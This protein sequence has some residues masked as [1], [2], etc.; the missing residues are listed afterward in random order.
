M[1][2]ERKKIMNKIVIVLKEDIIEYPPVISILNLLSD[3]PYEIYFLGTYTDVKGKKSLE[4]KG[5]KFVDMPPYDGKA[6]KVKKMMLQIEFRKQV[7]IGLSKIQLSKDDVL[8]LIQA[9]TIY[10]LSSLVKK[11]KTICHFL[12]FA[13]NKVDWKYRLLNPRLNLADTL[14]HAYR[15]VCCEYNR[16]QIAKGIFQLDRLPVVLPNKM[17]IN[18]D[19]N[20]PDDVA[21]IIGE[22][23]ERLDG[24]KI[25]LYQGIFLDKERRLEEFCEAMGDLPD[26]YVFIAMG[27]GSEMYERLRK[28]YASDRILFIPF[29]R[30]PY[31]LQVTKMA[32]IG[33]LSYFPRK[34]SIG[35][36]LNPIY[37]APN[38]I[39]EYARFGV[40]M[41]SN[42]IPGLKY[43]YME[44]HCGKCVDYP[45][46]KKQIVNTIKS[47][48][49]DYSSYKDGAIEFYNSV[50]IQSI[51]LKEVL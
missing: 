31:H 16:A 28:Q 1:S 32:S 14:Q 47:V 27:K 8:W 49:D 13:D 48:M 34:G 22:L 5:I 6:N 45:M 51:I 3:T 39:F 21:K 46:N 2:I 23:K 30:P 11:Y 12:E 17:V 15:V 37:C 24:K 40:P 7:M 36:T 26:D 9:E 42:D 43:T 25:I 10:L 35:S 41:I 4:D 33:V 20:I 19:R 29:I 38:K 50:D 18:E 44:F